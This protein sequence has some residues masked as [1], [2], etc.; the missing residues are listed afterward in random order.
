M[1]AKAKKRA[2]LHLQDQLRAAGE[3]GVMAERVRV[4]EYLESEL[5]STGGALGAMLSGLG[6]HLAQAIRNGDHEQ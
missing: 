6:F 3:A 1:G 2:R 5:S 4:I